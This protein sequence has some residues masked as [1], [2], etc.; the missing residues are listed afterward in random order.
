[1]NEEKDYEVEDKIRHVDWG[2]GVILNKIDT[3]D[4]IF[5]TVDFERVGLKKLS[6]NFAPLEKL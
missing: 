4:D 1:M 3:K 6:V 2:M 5:I